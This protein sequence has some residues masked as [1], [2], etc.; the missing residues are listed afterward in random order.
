[1]NNLKNVVDPQQLVRFNRLALVVRI[2]W[3]RAGRKDSVG[4]QIQRRT[5]GR[6]PQT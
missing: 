4:A 6:A 1:V 3:Q 5:A 2:A